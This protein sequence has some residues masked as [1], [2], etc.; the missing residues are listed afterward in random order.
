MKQS[1]LSNEVFSSD[2]VTLFLS[3]NVVA[4]KN[5]KRPNVILIVAED[6]EYGDTDCTM[7]K[8]CHGIL[9]SRLSNLLRNCSTMDEP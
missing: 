2:I 4:Q 9:R 8:L 3:E 7:A 6:L 1:N 5:A